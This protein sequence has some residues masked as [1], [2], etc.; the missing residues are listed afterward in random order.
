MLEIASGLEKKTC[1]PATELSLLDCPSISKLFDRPRSPWDEKPPYDPLL[2]LKSLSCVMTTPGES[3]A[4]VS[5]PPPNGRFCSCCE[6]IV[7]P[8]CACVV[9][10]SGVSS[11]CT[12]TTVLDPIF[13]VCAP[14][15]DRPIATVT[16]SIFNSSNP[17]ATMLT[18]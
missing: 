4:A 17:E 14:I 15:A 11:P 12:C 10:M 16:F 8:T 5:N 6:S 1:G 13:S 2:L 18:E 9:E 3:S 7:A